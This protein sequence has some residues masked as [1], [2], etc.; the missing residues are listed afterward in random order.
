MQFSTQRYNTITKENINKMVIKFYTRI[1][2][3]DTI[4]SEVFKSKLGTDINST[5][6][7]E[8]I[9]LLTNFWAMIALQSNQYQGN[10]MMAHI[11]M[12]LTRDMFPIWLK[13]FFET[14]DS[15]YEQE[16][17]FVFKSRAENI[18][19]NFMRNLGL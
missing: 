14:I 6:W 7:K 9:E 3:E 17:G 19:M 11:D 13:M 8:H 1:L 12:G 15:L 16:Q 10:P 4:V 18:A 2:N 5:S